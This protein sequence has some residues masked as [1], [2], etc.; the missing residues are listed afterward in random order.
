MFDLNAIN[1]INEKAKKNWDK[2][3]PI[4]NAIFPDWNKEEEIFLKKNQR[5]NGEEIETSKT[6]PQNKMP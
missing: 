2:K 3:I 1:E 4:R 6:M 5:V